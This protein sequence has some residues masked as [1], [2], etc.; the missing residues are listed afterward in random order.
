[1]GDMQGLVEHVQSLK[2]DQKDTMKHIA[3]GIFTVRDLRD[4]LNN[5]MKMGPLSKMAGMIPGLSN[6]MGDVGD[7]EGSMKLKRMMYIMDSMT[8]KELDSDGKMFIQQPERMTRVAKGSGTS[9]R[10]VED[11]LTQHKMMAQMAKKM[12]GGMKAMQQGGMGRGAPNPQQLAAMQKR[13]QA[14]GA[15]APGPG[16][17]DMASMMRAL[18][19]PGGGGGMDMNKMMSQMASMFGGG[20][21]PRR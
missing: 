13:M 8:T 5:I 1:M 11:V 7:E 3:E 9:V 17:M 18:G 2:L 12:K 14:M 16:G 20:G 4:Q 15:G 19:G 21:G 6:L 10:E